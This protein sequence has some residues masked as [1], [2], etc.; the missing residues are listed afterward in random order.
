MASA[1]ILFV[2]A[3]RKKIRRSRRHPAMLVFGSQVAASDDHHSPAFAGLGRLEWRPLAPPHDLPLWLPA[4][5]EVLARDHAELSQ[6]TG[7]LAVRRVASSTEGVAT[8]C[9]GRGRFDQMLGACLCRSGYGG[10]RC[11]R[12]VP[13]RCNDDREKCVSGKITRWIGSAT[14]GSV[15][16]APS[17]LEWTRVL[18]RCS[19]QCDV[20]KNRCA[21]WPPT[22]DPPTVTA[23]LSVCAAA[24]PRRRCVCGERSRYPERHMKMCEMRGI[25]RLTPWRSSGWAR[26]EVLQPWH[27]WAQANHTPP[28]FEEKIGREKLAALWATPAALAATAEERSLAWCDRDPGP[29]TWQRARK[30]KL[31]SCRCYDG[32]GGRACHL[33]WLA[34]CVNQC[35]GRG[36]CQSGF[37]LCQPGWSGVDCS[38]PLVPPAPPPSVWSVWTRSGGASGG[39]SWLL[40]WEPQQLQR[41][42]RALPPLRPSV[43]VYELPG[44]FN[45]KLLETRFKRD[46][47]TYRRYVD[48]NATK[49][50]GCA[51]ARPPDLAAISPSRPREASRATSPRSRPP[52]TPT[53]TPM[54]ATPSAWSWRCTRRSSCRATAPSTPRRPTSSLCRSTAAA[55]SRASSAPPPPTPSS[56]PRRNGPP[57]CPRPCSAT[58]STAARCSGCR[59]ARSALTTAPRTAHRPRPRQRPRPRPRPPR[60]GALPVLGPAQRHRPHLCLPSRRG[61]VHRSGRAAPLDPALLVGPARAA[62]RQLDH[63]DARARVVLQGLRAVDVRVAPLLR[64]RQGHPDARLHQARHARE[65]AGAARPARRARQRFGRAGAARLALP[66]PRAGAARAALSPLL[67][68]HPAAGAPPL[69]GSRGRGPARLRQALA[70]RA[71]TPVRHRHHRHLRRRRRRRPHH[72][73][74]HR[75]PLRSTVVSSSRSFA[76]RPSVRYSRA[77]AGATSRRPC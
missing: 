25:E 75:P 15:G 69:P 18:S 33:N 30:L 20:T 40:D 12:I 70:P 17:C 51:V 31:S 59:R 34:F 23:P 3:L 6:Q 4:L 24:C 67:L 71:P 10:D 41:R 19:A 45:T 7:A 58:S 29:A 68:R 77:T 62:P 36:E 46:D 76:T 39:S 56:S 28:W 8:A 9:F 44:E 26:F 64:P 48:Q 21:R 13:E 72:Q 47:C 74:R 38:I 66:L 1:S 22:A 54:A 37:C 42:A 16:Q 2:A 61:R 53:P 49:W 14:T 57:G 60:A 5:R 63:L 35:S 50:A 55:T 11:E 52:L 32:M 27:L 73:P 65:V 43:Y